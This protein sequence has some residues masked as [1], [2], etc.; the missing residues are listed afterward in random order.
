MKV[1]VVVTS[2]YPYGLSESFLEQELIFLAKKFDYI[3]I[4]PQVMGGDIRLMPSNCFV[5]Y[6][7][8]NKFEVFISIL[9]NIKYISC[10]SNVVKSIFFIKRIKMLLS[11]LGNAGLLKNRI[12]SFLKS[13]KFINSRVFLYSY[14]MDRG[15]LAIA[16]MHDKRVVK[17]ISRAHGFDLYKDRSDD[18][19]LPYRNFI[20]DNIDAVYA[21]SENGEK[22]LKSDFNKYSEKIKCSKLGSIKEIQ[23]NVIDKKTIDYFTVV[24]VSGVVPVKRVDLIAE[25]IIKFAKNSL[26]NVSWIH[27]GD[28]PGM[29]SLLKIVESNACSNLK[30][31]IKGA[32]KNNSIHEFYKNNKV[33]LFINLSAS[34][35]IPVSFMEAMSYG[36]PVLGT[37]VGGVSEIL[38]KNSS[39]LVDF[40]ESSDFYAKKITE[41]FYESDYKMMGV[42]A[43]KIWESMYNAEENYSTFS[44]ELSCEK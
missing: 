42:A 26:K 33:D 11:Y 19:Y 31:C 6:K 37:N 43:Q 15:S 27:F 20:I 35:G 25:S 3:Y 21:V 34:E 38:L 24:S 22:Y 44:E 17:K 2:S 4:F 1:L 18:N 28:G 23:S 9:R 39:Y 41:V 12:E 10:D 8:N 7:S 30:I 32:V 14:W 13:E 16:L 40:C 36:I 29:G 5:I